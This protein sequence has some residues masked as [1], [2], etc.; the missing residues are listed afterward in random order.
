MVGLR[1]LAWFPPR[2]PRQSAQMPEVQ[3]TALT[4]LTSDIPAMALRLAGL[5]KTVSLLHGNDP[6]RAGEGLPLAHP[7][8]ASPPGP[9]LAGC[10]ISSEPRDGP[11]AAPAQPPPAAQGGRGSSLSLGAP[12]LSS[13][14]GTWLALTS[15]SVTKLGPGFPFLVT[16]SVY[17]FS[18]LPDMEPGLN[19]AFRKLWNF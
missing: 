13:L 6:S 2:C 19:P 15:A 10:C 7:P 4:S 17:N 14:H 9:Y 12:F 16:H 11:D 8:A 3:W 18:L 5:G 1:P